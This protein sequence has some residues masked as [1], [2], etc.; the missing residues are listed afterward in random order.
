MTFQF[1]GEAK[2]YAENAQLVDTMK[3]ITTDEL[4]DMFSGVSKEVIRSLKPDPSVISNL[5]GDWW[6]AMLSQ[7]PDNRPQVWCKW[8]DYSI[9]TRS[10]VVLYV[11]EGNLAADQK[12]QLR[13]IAKNQPGWG[14]VEGDDT[15]WEFLHRRVEWDNKDPVATLHDAVVPMLQRLHKVFPPL[16]QK[17]STPRKSKR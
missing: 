14:V 6:Y 2:L 8:Y 10:R 13:A 11:G 3:R 7:P 17:K 15:D 5:N 9:I 1:S 12:K 16:P 4:R